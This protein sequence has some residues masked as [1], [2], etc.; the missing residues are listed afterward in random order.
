MLE[1]VQQ[2][3]RCLDDAHRDTAINIFP[4]SSST[5]MEQKKIAILM[6]K[7]LQEVL[8]TTSPS[9]RAHCLGGRKHRSLSCLFLSKKIRFIDR[10]QTIRHRWSERQ[11]KIYF[12]FSLDNLLR[13][14]RMLG[15]HSVFHS[16]DSSMLLHI[17]SGLSSWGT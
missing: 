12:C 1:C 5:E 13:S 15:K 7:G 10:R 8:N 16:S 9:T 11:F 2:K 14:V 17:Y 4:F 3:T 6:L